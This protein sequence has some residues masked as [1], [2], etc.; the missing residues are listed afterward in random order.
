M[1]K[2]IYIYIK[3]IYSRRAKFDCG[4]KKAGIPKGDVLYVSRRSIVK[5]CTYGPSRS[6]AGNST[7]NI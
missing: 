2:E 3:Y 6:R 1:V 4:Y 7:S 5:V